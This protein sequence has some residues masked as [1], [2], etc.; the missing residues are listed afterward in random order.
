MTARVIEALTAKSKL[1]RKIRQHLKKI[2]FIKLDDGS[3]GLPSSEKE[4]IRNL[5]SSQR[6]ERVKASVDF[7]EQKLPK[8]LKYFASGNEINPT[9]ISPV[10]KRVHSG[11][12]ESDLFR[13]ASLTWSVPVSPGFG[14]RLRYLVWDDYHDKLIGLIAI[15]DPVFNLTVRDKHIGWNLNDRTKRLVNLLDAYV[16]GAVPPYNMLLGGKLVASLLRTKELY[17]DFRKQYGNATGIISGEEK[18]PRLLAITTS[19]SM[20]KSSVY[21]RLKL[22]GIEYL[23]PIGYT[24]GWGHFHIP[25]NI[26]S[27]MRNYL[28][29]IKHTYADLHQFGDGPNWRLRTARAALDALGFREDLLKHGIGREVFICTLANNSL[30][31]LETGKGRPDTSTLLSVKEVGKLAIDRWIIPRSIA[32]TEYLNW[33]N[34]QIKELIQTAKATINNNINSSSDHVVRRISNI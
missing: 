22:D 17:V 21:N 30:K 24:K 29:A 18:A 12:W 10:L 1:K 16:L 33:K 15:G 23:K 27:D 8:L 34:D 26:F 5:H 28:R 13:L 31:I 2:G 9:L 3:L 19:S 7:I 32:R 20:G 4:I 6:D 11:T 14:R 25:E